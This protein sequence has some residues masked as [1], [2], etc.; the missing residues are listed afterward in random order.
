MNILFGTIQF[1][2]QAFQVLPD[3]E[4]PIPDIEPRPETEVAFR[5]HPASWIVGLGLAYGLTGHAV[6]AD[7][8]WNHVIKT[9]RPV[10]DDAK[11]FEFCRAGNISGVKSLLSERAA[12]PWDTNPAGWT[13][14]HV[15]QQA[16]YWHSNAFLFDLGVTNIH[17]VAAQSVNPELCKLLID[18]AA[19]RS[20]RPYKYN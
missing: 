5:F 9:F 15:S 11:I 20:A 12:S 18:A 4:E 17:K 1:S 14:L 7:L 10:R 16:Q 19:D 2:S 8:N 13:P 6:I 3:E